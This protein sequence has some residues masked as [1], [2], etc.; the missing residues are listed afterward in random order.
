MASNKDLWQLWRRGEAPMVTC[1]YSWL[2]SQV[3]DSLNVLPGEEFRVALREAQVVSMALPG[4]LSCCT[5][6]GLFDKGCEGNVLLSLLCWSQLVSMALQ[7]DLSCCTRPDLNCDI[8]CTGRAPGPMLFRSQVVSMALQGD[9]S[10]CTR[11][12]LF[13]ISRTGDA[14]SF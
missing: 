8:S 14:L 13:N 9:L 12:G 10:C 7:G 6:H 2:L 5:C 1:M 11:H 4:D 3:G